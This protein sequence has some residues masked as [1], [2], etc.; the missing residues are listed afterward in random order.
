[1]KNSKWIIGVAVLTVSAS[2]AMAAPHGD[3]HGRHGKEQGVF[4]EKL[5][6]KLNLNDTQKQQLRDL[7][8]SF[9]EENKAF[10][11]TFRQTMQDYR[12]AKEGNDT[13]KIESL[14]S[15]V[16]SQKAQMGQLRAA[17]E[18]RFM[19]ILTPD[20]RTQYQTMKSKHDKR[21]PQ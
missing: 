9:R 19:S 14:Q 10:F 6:Q 7:N 18:E 17:K 8:T 12:D 13:A 20:Q 16:E 2:L 21:N 3:R 5:A 11:Q 15:T 1:M 4:S